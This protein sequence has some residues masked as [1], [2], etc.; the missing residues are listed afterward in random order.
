MLLKGAPV[1]HRT[2]LR[3]VVFVLTQLTAQSVLAWCTVPEAQA[4]TPGTPDTALLTPASIGPKYDKYEAWP[5]AVSAA[6][7]YIVLVHGSTDSHGFPSRRTTVVRV[8]KNKGTTWRTVRILTTPNMT[9]LGGIVRLPS[10]R[11]VLMLSDVKGHDDFNWV[12][13][14]ASDDHGATWK[15]LSARTAWTDPWSFGN[16][17][18]IT[19]PGTA[20]RL[21]VT[22]NNGTAWG[23]ASSADEGR[24]WTRT[25]VK[26]EHHMY[27]GRLV[28]VPGTSRLIAIG[29]SKELGPILFKSPDCGATWT[30]HLTEIP[31]YVTEGAVRHGS[32]LRMVTISR[33]D[34]RMEVRDAHLPT[35]YDD[36]TAWSSPRLLRR[37]KPAGL[38]DIGYP[39]VLSA[40]RSFDL[41]FWYGPTKTPK[42]PMIY[43]ARMAW[44]E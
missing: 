4:L 9:G 28:Q 33:Y 16:I 36:A 31:P 43:G 20:P 22:W 1:T 12:Q 14:Y 42:A 18:R 40:S 44:R 38:V 5:D 21:M 7:G 27:E 11:L 13:T 26:T 35:L 17:E 30:S 2:W 32:T 34:Q 41:V 24:T 39:V 10:G 37:L 23:V 25:T 8:S 19:C 15:P 29:R 6:N 3:A